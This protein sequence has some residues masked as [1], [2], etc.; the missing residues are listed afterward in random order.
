MFSATDRAIWCHLITF[1]FSLICSVFF[2]IA[3][4]KTLSWNKAAINQRG[5]LDLRVKH[6]MLL[7][8]RALT[9]LL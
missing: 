5:R 1:P 7:E 3:T 9:C 2:I 8:L 6:R 4:N